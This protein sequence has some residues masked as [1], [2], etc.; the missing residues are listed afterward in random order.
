MFL[1]IEVSEGILTL[2]FVR[3]DGTNRENS[4]VVGGPET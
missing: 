1:K 2:I 3:D 4:K